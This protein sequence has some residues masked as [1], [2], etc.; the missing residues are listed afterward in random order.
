MP[1]FRYSEWDGSQPFGG[2][3]SE[4]LYDT[5]SDYLLEYGEHVLQQIDQPADEELQEMLERLLDEGW[6]ERDEQGRLIPTPKGLMRTQRRALEQ[7]FQQAERGPTGQHATEM[8]GP[9]QVLHEETKPYQYGDPLTNLNLPETMKRAVQRQGPRT[10]IRLSPDDFVV[11][12]TEHL[13]RSATVVLVDMSGSMGRFGK[14]YQA[15]QVAL[16]L[17]ALVRGAYPEDTI[18]FVGFYSYAT[19]LGPRDLLLASPKPVSLWTDRVFLR[20]DLD[21]PPAFVPEHFTNIQAGLR[22]ARSLLRRSGAQQRQIILI[23]DGEPTAHLE[24]RN[25]LLIYPPSRRTLQHT[26]AEARRCVAEGIKISTFALVDDYLYFELANF[27][28]Q[29][30]QLTQGVAV[31]CSARELGKLVLESFERG[32]YRRRVL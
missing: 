23:T 30:A 15:K 28:R 1:R 20:I 8:R 26:L 18:D 7:L 31:H 22:I 19:R 14:F 9:G 5:L 12:D 6:L 17:Q 4:R 16:A 21:A 10:P 11:Y 25:L 24:G 29:L 13:T 27:V 2:L 3:E 32:R